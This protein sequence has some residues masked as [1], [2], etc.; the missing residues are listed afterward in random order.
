MRKPSRLG[1][2]RD[3]FRR[4]L[5]PHATP[6]RGGILVSWREVL[7]DPRTPTFGERHFRSGKRFPRLRRDPLAVWTVWAD[8]CDHAFVDGFVVMPA[9]ALLKVCERGRKL[10]WGLVEGAR[11]NAGLWARARDHQMLPVGWASGSRR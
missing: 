6:V 11:G 10:D 4:E 2:A 7:R 1:D 8:G 9:S 5:D 3:G